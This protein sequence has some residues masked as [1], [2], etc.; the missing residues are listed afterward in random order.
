MGEFI[1]DLQKF[2]VEVSGNKVTIPATE[3]Y[4]LDGV[5]YTAV[6]DVQLNLDS[7]GKVS[8]I[9]SGK[10]EA[11]AND[12]D[13]SP[14]VTFDT[15]EGAINFVATGNGEVITVKTLFPIEFIG[16]EFTYKGN[17][18]TVA[19]GS[20]LANVA[21][22][23]SYALR[24]EDYFEHGATYT[25][26]ADALIIDSKHTSSTYTLT[27]G[28]EKV[29][30]HPES[31]GRV[32]NHFSERGFTLVKGS[33]ES[34][35]IG[36][37]TLKATA[38]EDTS[39]NM[40]LGSEGVTIIP[41]PRDG[42]LNVAISHGDSV[43]IQGELECTSGSITLGYDNSISFAKGTNFNFKQGDYIFTS[44]VTDAATV[45]VALK[46]NGIVFTLGEND[47]G[48]N[49]LIK[50]GGNAI[51]GGKINVSDGS[52]FFNVSTQEI[53]F[54]EGTN[55]SL[56]IDGENPQKVDFK[57]VGGDAGFN[58][59]AVGNGSFKITPTEGDGT[60]DITLNSASGSL[61]ANVELL[62]GSF[63]LGANGTINVA[64]DTEL[65]ID[66]GDGYIIKFKAT[67]DAGGA[68][69]LGAGG[70]TFAPNSSDGGLELSVTRDGETRT[71]SLDVTGSVTYKLDGSI[72]LD[73]GTVIENIFEDGSTLKIVAN[74]DANGSMI[75]APQNGLII[76]SDTPEALNVILTTGE[77]P[78]LTIT[79]ITGTLNYKGGVVT[80]SDGTKADLFLYDVWKSVI[81]TD[82]GSA[83]FQPSPEKAIFT[84]NEGSTFSIIYS[85][86][87]SL[88]LQQGTLI[89]N[90][91]GEETVKTV[92]SV[93]S[94]L[95]CNDDECL[96]LLEKAGTYTL[97]GMKV[98]TTS[99][100]VTVCLKNY[101]TII[102][103]SG[104]SYTTTDDNVTLTIDE[105]GSKITGGEVSVPME[106]TDTPLVIDATNG[107]LSFD[108]E[109]KTFFFEEGTVIY[110]QIDSDT[111]V[112]F[113]VKKD[114]SITAEKTSEG[115]FSLEL[116]GAAELDIVS[117]TR[118]AAFNFTG[119]MLYESGG[120]IFLQDGTE[121]NLAWDDGVDLKLTSHGSRGFISFNADKGLQITSEDEKLDMTLTTEHVSTDVRGIKGTIYYKEGNV[122]LDD[123]SKVTATAT[124]GGQTVLATL[125]SVGGTGHISFSNTANGVFYSAGTGA[126]RITLI[127][128]DKESVL[129]VNKG[130]IQIGNNLF[131]IA[132]D[133]NVSTD[134]KDFIPALYFKTS[135]AGNYTINGQKITTTAANLALTATDDEMVFTT[136]DDAVMCN[137]MTF[138]GAGRVSLSSDSVVLGAG[139]DA[140]GFGKGK[141]FVLAEAG[142]VTAD[143]RIFEL[144]EEVPTGITVMGEQDGFVFSRT[145]TKES[146]ER[147][148]YY[149]SPDI[150][151]IF[152][153]R[154]IAVGDNSYR[155]QTD[156]IGLEKVIG[157]SDGVS[158]TG[159]ANLDDERT[160]CYYD[161]V[162]DSTGKFTIGKK[163]YTI[164]EDADIDLRARF[165]ENVAY[166]SKVDRLNGKIV[167]DFSEGEFSVNGS[168][169]LRIFGDSQVEIL[170]TDDN[171][172]IM[173]LDAGA[174]LKVAA[175]GNYTVNKTLIEAEAGGV[176][177]GNTNG[178]ANIY[179]ENNSS[180]TLLTGTENDDQITNIG[181][182]VTIKALGGNDSIVN[183]VDSSV[184]TVEF[185]NSI[186]AGAGDDQI[187]NHHSYNPT[188]FGGEGD[189]SI[190]VSRGHKTFVD[191]GAGND[192]IE[193]VF[194]DN[195]DSDWAMGGFATISGG[196][197]DDFIDTGYTNDS[198][199][200]AGAG[201]DTI[202]T[203]GLNN[204]IN[205]GDGENLI[206]VMPYERDPN[207][208]EGSFVFFNGYTTVHGFK[209]GFGEGTDTV[210]FANDAPACNFLEDGLALY[211]DDGEDSYS[212]LYF[213]GVTK[214]TK[215]NLYYEKEDKLA[216]EV[217]ISLDDWYTVENEDFSDETYFVGSTALP[218]EGISFK[219]I[220]EPLNISLDTDYSANV[221]FW[222]NNIYSIVGGAGNTTI[223]GSEKSDTIIAGNG[224]TT[225]DAKKGDDFITASSKTLINYSAGD[226]ND[227]I[228]GFTENSTLNIKG[229]PYSLEKSGADLILAVKND[230]IT[231][232][233]A[234]NLKSLNI[235]GIALFQTDETITLEDDSIDLSDSTNKKKIVLSGAEEQSV[236][237]NDAGGNVII[238]TENSSGEKNIS[239]GAGDDFVVNNGGNVNINFGGGATRVIASGG[240]T[241]FE[242]YNPETGAGIVIGKNNIA[243]AISSGEIAFDDG[244]VSIGSAVVDL[245]TKDA[246]LNFY[247]TNNNLQKVVFVSDD[248]KLDASDMNNDLIIVGGK[249]STIL[250][251]KGND[252]LL[253]GE[254]SSLNAG[255]GNNVIV[256][257][258]NQNRDGSNIVL[259]T[260]TGNTLIKNANNSFS[261][262]FGDVL[263]ISP[264]NISYNGTDLI[265]KGKNFTATVEKPVK[266]GDSGSEFVNQLVK[267]ADGKVWRMAIGGEDSFVDVK[268][269]KSLRADFYKAGGLNLE[270]YSGKAQIDLSNDE[271]SLGSMIDGVQVAFEGVE[272]VKAGSGD[273]S[274]K[275]SEA[276]ET[277]IA[278]VGNVSMYGAGGNNLLVGYD[279]AAS[280]K[281]GST[282][283]FVL[284]FADNAQN[285]IQNF[286]FV[287]DTN[288]T[289]KSADIIEIDTANNL[290]RQE[291]VA[292][293]KKDVIFSVENRNNG[294]K[295]FVR[296]ENAASTSDNVKDMRFS[297]DLT[298]QV[299]TN[300][301]YFDKFANFYVATG[302][303]AT[304]K[305]GNDTAYSIIWLD[306]LAAAENGVDTNVNFVGDI[307]VI[308]ATGS[309][310]KTELAGN[311]F[312]NTICA[313]DGDS[314]LWGGNSGND[315][316]IGGKG[317][318]IFFYAFGNGNDSVAGANDGDNVVLADISLQQI[319]NTTIT[320][321]SVI[322]SFVDG[323]SLI[324]EGNSNVAFQ[325]A[326]GSKYLANHQT[327]R[328]QQ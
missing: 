204:T 262:E 67:G 145:L 99:D 17:T 306:S 40:E 6:D 205:G 12:A 268:A 160:Y 254:N 195:P 293:S 201:N 296:V 20:I 257:D 166:A 37:Y 101:D 323:G 32:I 302:S 272:S 294:V 224:D 230:S 77:L 320:D 114:F 237:T 235:E 318:S 236:K 25:F 275:G 38:T 106:G 184:T 227:V 265:I 267:D 22:Y 149:D 35:K 150:G 23:G 13:N 232:S 131:T 158:V 277:L 284:G 243:E 261:A 164:S 274:I 11:V 97:N 140:A 182:N 206:Y 234:A 251:G 225:I 264:S 117:G 94:I 308:D 124:I 313:G 135:D 132:L 170:G 129:T 199:I 180:D 62:S 141:S 290:I 48:L 214:T 299:A 109:T 155:I 14:V 183:N 281:Q 287:N 278:G 123:N 91:Y 260:A 194:A 250:S 118:K 238:V 82:G 98:N 3:T 95:R 9:V 74:I 45:G 16:G 27:N 18:L 163:T 138:L 198:S 203:S 54:S 156:L 173:G 211:D 246:L 241:S 316:L 71:A 125:E 298:A 100:N 326:D 5:T 21:Q 324:V 50:R 213:A 181:T 39:L 192:T 280:L 283:F 43:V 57:I 85:D 226:G 258:S 102:T 161:L 68:I 108:N 309:T 49:L 229:A 137:G 273:T 197:G 29:E 2:A 301:L 176:I 136:S 46:E 73:K 10:V 64:E 79:S 83:S 44:S 215:L 315:V 86:G 84:A 42:S 240:V 55:I 111:T 317:E 322:I 303:N 187:Y 259:G 282:T 69:S 269:D 196:D 157:I 51:F 304:V 223:T 191:A 253:A 70:I 107:S 175:A 266:D 30:L 209:T 327:S 88:E 126:L 221:N 249:N 288:Y 311:D 285:T 130:S 56:S 128:E 305:V 297:G 146:E 78:I 1:F 28:N 252:T 66:F 172:E 217:F 188:I 121:L 179:I 186:D 185:G 113:I 244:K 96:F 220:S 245:G 286:A 247:D 112:Q 127:K 119:N 218:N 207:Y 139:V 122:L 189:D 165:D 115:K 89:D 154:F 295:E 307:R 167:G 80:I 144:T 63:I 216:Q 142:D 312:D 242:N 76:S 87:V 61:N 110:F 255:G 15:S 116:D 233:G 60:L 159:S 271:N 325:L 41:S 153:E 174:S 4:N 292:I 321:N 222:V 328:W 171:F 193:G 93:G 300:D 33:S 81:R 152:S 162:T 143:A 314:S 103:E 208:K 104:I 105:S 210:Y 47:G 26:T 72:S 276:N 289:S 147:L 202:I 52:I 169:A 177:V 7:D 148:G 200:D 134:L 8:G 31:S 256:L 59:E 178:S 248:S 133:T 92:I 228:R 19:A 263:E 168:A 36:D 58:V 120:K 270:N 219:N 90:Y 34:V 291:S 53:T 279:G 310:V 24:N 151:K 319:A 212:R 231:L 65:K 75:F 239:C 190:A